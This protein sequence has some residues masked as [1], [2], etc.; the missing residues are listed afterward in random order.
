MDI[1]I[2]TQLGMEYEYLELQ[3]RM[4]SRDV[5]SLE[6]GVLHAIILTLSAG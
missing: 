5:T 4:V 2:C 1:Y 6:A 3:L